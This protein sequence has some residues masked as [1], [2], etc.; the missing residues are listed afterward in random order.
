MIPRFALIALALFT[1]VSTGF[2]ADAPPK[3]ATADK[4]PAKPEP[5]AA[6]VRKEMMPVADVAGLPRVLLIG[7]SISIG[8]T[9][10]VRDL[11][12]G[13]A[14]VHRNLD[15][16]NGET[17]RNGVKSL[18]KWLGDAKWD[19]IHFNHGL[20]DIKVMAGD[21]R[22][23]ELDEYEKNLR[24]IVARLKKTG[25]KLIFATTTPVPEGKVSPARVPADVVKYNE[26][27]VKVMKEEG[28][29]VDDLYAVA[30]PK[31]K[32]IQLSVNVHFNKKGSQ[33]LAEQVAKSIEEALKK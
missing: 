29:A 5:G 26:V 22:Q 12:K 17:S 14:N 2:A 10:P 4:P 27:A 1:T 23:V 25:A 6:A 16:Y 8:Y 18:D 20:H 11:L 21:V 31:L 7:D 3:P 28:V 24:A 33:L 32:E 9:L 15:P 13:K 19:V 30:Q